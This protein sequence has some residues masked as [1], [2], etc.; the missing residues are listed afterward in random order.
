MAI[1]TAATTTVQAKHIRISQS[2]PPGDYKRVGGAG[3]DR[4]KSRSAASDR[5]TRGEPPKA[6]RL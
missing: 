5:P 3:R 4:P 6:D 1:I 2:L